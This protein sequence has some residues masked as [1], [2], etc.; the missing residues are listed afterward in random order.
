M[1]RD[2]VPHPMLVW[3]TDAER[4]ELHRQAV[5][6]GTDVAWMARVRLVEGLR[7]AVESSRSVS[8]SVTPSSQQD[9]ESSAFP[10]VRGMISDDLPKIDNRRVDVAEQG[11]RVVWRRMTGGLG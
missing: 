1:I 9:R 2:D 5:V 11:S 6:R 3:V 7:G 4:A 10:Q 8:G